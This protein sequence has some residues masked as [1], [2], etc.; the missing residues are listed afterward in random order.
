MN[1][2][3]KI[4]YN[5]RIITISTILL[6]I[7]IATAFSAYSYLPDVYA[8]NTLRQVIEINGTYPAGV[9]SFN[10][11][12]T[13]PLTSLEKSVAFLT[14]NYNQQNQ[15]RDTFRSWNF[16]DLSTLTIYGNDQTPSANFQVGFHGTIFEFTADSDAFVQ[17]LE[18]EIAPLAA[19]GEFEVAI[20]TAVNAS[21]AFLVQAGNFHQDVDTTVGVEEFSRIRII[22]G[23][24]YG[25]LIGD[26]PNTGPMQFHNSI[27]DLNTTGV[28]VQ[29]GLGTIDSGETIDTIVPT[30]YNKTNTILFVSYSTNGMFAQDPEDVAVKATI[31]GA[32]NII[33]ERTTASVDTVDYSFELIEFEDGFLIA[34]HFNGTQADGTTD[35]FATIPTAVGNFSRSWAIGTVS[36]PFGLGNGLSDSTVN[37]GFDRTTATITL[38]NA[39]H[40][41]LVRGTGI[42]SYEVGLQ[43][44][45]F[46]EPLVGL[47]QVIND[48]SNVTDTTVLNLTKVLN[49]NSNVT[50]TTVL[51]LTK[52]LN[53]NSNVTDSVTTL[54]N[55]SLTLDSANNNANITDSVI[56]AINKTLVGDI[57]NATDSV[58]AVLSSIAFN[59]TNND[60]ANVTDAH[61]L[62]TTKV[63]LTTG[64]GVGGGLSLNGVDNSTAPNAGTLGSSADALYF[65]SDILS[66]FVV[67]ASGIINEGVIQNGTSSL[68]TAGEI[69]FGT[70]PTDWNFIHAGNVGNNLTSINFWLNGDVDGAA[71]YPLI[72]TRVAGGFAGFR[73]F[74]SAATTCIKLDETNGG[75]TIL[76]GCPAGLPAD[77]G[78]WHMVTFVLDKGNTTKSIGNMELCVDSVCSRLPTSG[79]LQNFTG[80]FDNAQ[81]ALEIGNEQG[82]NVFNTFNVDEVT[83]WEGYQ[84]TQTDINNMWNSGVGNSSDSIG[85]SFQILDVNFDL[86]ST[87]AS[88]IAEVSDSVVTQL[89][90][91]LNQT[92]NDNANVTDAHILDTNKVLNDTDTGFNNT[93]LEVYWKFEETSGILTTEDFVN[94]P[95]A[96]S[97]ND[98]GMNK[99]NTG[100]FGNAWRTADLGGAR[101]NITGTVSD[102]D[103]IQSGSHS[104][105]LWMQVPDPDNGA[106]LGILF[107]THTG[108]ASNGGQID[109]ITD[110]SNRIRYFIGKVPVGDIL[111]T[112]QASQYWDSTCKPNCTSFQM[113]TLTANGTSGDL[114]FYRN[115]TLFQTNNVF[116]P[117]PTQVPTTKLPMLLASTSGSFSTNKASFDE[118]SIWS[119]V[120]TPTEV[121]NL[122]NNGTGL[123]LSTSSGNNT[124]VI[125]TD[126]VVTSLLQDVVISNA[127]NF[128]NVTDQ[129]ILNP[130][131][132]I[133]D[134][135]TGFNT[136]SLM[137]YYHLD[138]VRN[139]PA[140]PEC[141][142]ESFTVLGSAA[143]C[144]TAT[145]I[146]NVTGLF[147]NAINFTVPTSSNIALGTTGFCPNDSCIWDFNVGPI[148]GTVTYNW[149][150]IMKD[151][152]STYSIINTYIEGTDEDGISIIAQTGSVTPSDNTL[153]YEMQAGGTIH[154]TR[155]S[156]D[157][158]FLFDGNFHMYTIVHE[159]GGFPIAAD[160]Q[161]SFFRDGVLISQSVGVAFNFCPD[162]GIN[163]ETLC[164]ND[165][166]PRIMEF[167][168]T[169]SLVMDELTFWDRNVTSTELLT[170]HNGGAGLLITSGVG[171]NNTGVIV[172]DSVVVALLQ[173]VVISN[174]TNF[175]NVTDAHI[176]DTIKVLN[177]TGIGGGGG[178]ETSFQVLHVPFNSGDQGDNKGTLG[179]LGDAQ[180]F[181]DNSLSTFFDVTGPTNLDNAVRQNGTNDDGTPFA[182]GRTQGEIRFGSVG[183]DFNFLHVGNSGDNVTSINFWVKGDLDG[184]PEYTMLSNC[185]SNGGCTNGIQIYTLDANTRLYMEENNQVKVAGQ[186]I[187]NSIPADDSNWHMV[188]VIFDKGNTTG[189]A[190]IGCIDA[191]C[192]N[193][194]TWSNDPVGNGGNPTEELALGAVHFQSSLVETT[195]DYDDLTIWN[196]YQLTQ[197][198]INTLYNSGNGTSA[199]GSIGSLGVV[200]TDTVNAFISS[201]AFNQTIND[202][203]NVTDATI[204]NFTKLLDDNANVTD[205]V[206]ITADF[207]QTVGT[208]DNNVNVT[209]SVTIINSKDQIIPSGANTAIISDSIVLN[210]TKFLDDE[211][212]ISDNATINNATA[213]PVPPPPSGGGSS[214]G[215]GVPTQ[216]DPVLSASL[217]G[218]SLTLSE[219][220]HTLSTE[221]I[222]NPFFTGVSELGVVILNWDQQEPIQITDISVP[223]QFEGFVDFAK[224]E[225]QTLD[226]VGAKADPKDT[227]STGLLAYEVKIPSLALGVTQDTNPF[228]A[229]VE[230]FSFIQLV[231][232]NQYT[233]PVTVDAIH[234]GKPFQ[235]TGEIV[236]NHIKEVRWVVIALTIA[237]GVFLAI[238]GKSYFSATTSSKTGSFRKNLDKARRAT[239][240]KQKPGS[241]RKNLEQQ[242]RAD[243]RK[244]K[245]K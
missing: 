4:F 205:T 141:A 162:R 232:T 14:F 125:V 204:L 126:S 129:N 185:N 27:V 96:D 92:N 72:D 82:G 26:T 74:T 25:V 38:Q 37:G 244:L 63:I 34:Q 203:V 211:S 65:E 24:F 214:G 41:E 104:Y 209:D 171:G 40:V 118:W 177:D 42:S 175:V 148:E 180:Y 78:Q 243:K 28:N 159:R 215:G 116:N 7:T 227:F 66:T 138:D 10:V 157:G 238:W 2:G 240:D 130:N 167:T 110:G 71:E 173:D 64:G 35:S 188:S 51:N 226:F 235:F 32:D 20:P 11:T 102:W 45:E 9:D 31:N 44:I 192:Q 3:M 29:R 62:N 164:F 121:T 30:A 145:S 117:D 169:S 199:G 33:I 124:G 16:T 195:T 237:G 109:V 189:A 143:D 160:Q 163:T 43:V 58:N 108:G 206:I 48:N 198:D 133:S 76:S 79:F 81:H 137:A 134:T 83:V 95:D 91:V 53:D 229:A 231:F 202:N 49:D 68:D 57:V 150:A 61:I 90:Q 84:V 54:L 201:I 122:F 174:A 89:T 98:V 73:I 184:S 46:L 114:K 94:I 196:G 181:E 135:D 168:G 170:L 23:T 8:D 50:D 136:T 128:V 156:A 6:A 172:T 85:S 208:V 140:T 210:F 166:P 88:N 107:A 70:T 239:I 186:I 99:T 67:N 69:R 59:Q 153:I 194:A 236:I 182:P 147:G 176:L 165:T 242:R 228:G 144:A 113:V 111:S 93:G 161:V 1:I 179:V 15:H 119:R 155:T 212:A 178:I 149:W 115:G 216:P 219:P 17:H 19:E 132:V 112:T 193:T 142:N 18:F 100:V 47:T 222:I 13:P 87:I 39:T 105:N 223:T 56:L 233:I 218:I 245:R 220:E 183:S 225:G 200:V 22:N 234:D 158:I 97:I 221:I 5:A 213:P 217:T 101:I 36:S 197:S 152:N 55:L 241:F 224:Q 106:T 127:T 77:D 120:L 146:Q 191:V 86:Q 139:S 230:F 75:T 207:N 103:F 123:E 60:N 154:M 190:I 12:I 151:T 80:T 21:T 187:K 131:K 52:V